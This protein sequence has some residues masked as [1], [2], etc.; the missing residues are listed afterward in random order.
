[1]KYYN[2]IIINADFK[3]VIIP[4]NNHYVIILIILTY[5]YSFSQPKNSQQ[6]PPRHH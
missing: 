1:M 5:N 2:K 3:Q 6:Q 4:F